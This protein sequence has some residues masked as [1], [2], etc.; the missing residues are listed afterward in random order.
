MSMPHAYRIGQRLLT[1]EH[2]S[3]AYEQPLLRDVS[4]SIDNIVRAR[5]HQGQ[6]VCVLG[7]PGIGKTQLLRCIA[8]LQAPLS[9][10]IFLHDQRKA[11]APGDI[12]VVAQHCPLLDHR[13]VLGNLLLAEPTACRQRAYKKVLAMLLEFGLADQAQSYPQELNTEQRLLVAIAQQLLHGSHFLLIDEP[14]L[15][16]DPQAKSTV[17]AAI[18]KVSRFYELNTILVVTRDI[19]A[20]TRI[21]DTLWLLGRE[22]DAHGRPIP[23]AK[24]KYHYDL[25]ERGIAW[26]QDFEYTPDFFALCEELQQ[27]FRDL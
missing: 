27:R 3:L 20:A 9:G 18:L 5:M 1:I 4:A 7:P 23:G 22:R 25:I 19:M 13:T 14:F 26:Q 8:G 6:V 17:C 10:N 2:I 12:G 11:V 15:G 21:A 16:L 24:I